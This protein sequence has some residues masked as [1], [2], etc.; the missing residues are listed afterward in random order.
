MLGLRP[1]DLN[2]AFMLGFNFTEVVHSV[3]SPP[4][5]VIEPMTD[6]PGSL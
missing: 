4:T 5:G 2:F 1:I 6:K 3:Q